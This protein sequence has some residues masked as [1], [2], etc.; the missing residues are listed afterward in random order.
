MNAVNVLSL[1]EVNLALLGIGHLPVIRQ[2]TQLLLVHVWDFC[3]GLGGRF[4]GLISLSGG[5]RGGWCLGGHFNG[6][7]PRG[8]S[9]LVLMFTGL[10]GSHT[11]THTRLFLHILSAHTCRPQWTSHVPCMMSQSQA[12]AG[13]WNPPPR[14][15]ERHRE[16]RTKST[17]EKTRWG[18]R[19]R[20]AGTDFRGLSMNQGSKGREKLVGAITW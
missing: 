5:L 6:H 8:I 14:E 10:C 17:M 13:P 3:R 20:E 16:M 7:L 1:Y 2:R 4:L 11:P 12:T 15:G 18:D 19:K 9:A